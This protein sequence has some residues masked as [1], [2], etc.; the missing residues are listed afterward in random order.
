MRFYMLPIRIRV[1]GSR[2]PLGDIVKLLQM[3][4][5]KITLLSA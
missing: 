5:S 4:T 3:K 1:A 2:C